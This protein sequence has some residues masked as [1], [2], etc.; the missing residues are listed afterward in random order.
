MTDMEIIMISEVSQTDTN[1]QCYYMWNLAKG[2]NELL[3]RID[4]DSQTLKHL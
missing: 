3:C 4:T 1:I 2:Y